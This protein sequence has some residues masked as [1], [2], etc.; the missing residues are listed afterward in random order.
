MPSFIS[1]SDRRF[2]SMLALWVVMLS[3]A[4]NVLAGY[5]LK[6]WS[7]LTRRV[8][9]GKFDVAASF[10]NYFLNY[11]RCPIVILGS[12]V[13]AGLPPE[14]WER[15]DVCTITLVG[16]GSFLGLE[17]LAKF[18]AAP[19]VLF[20]ES[21]FGFRD[22]PADQ[23]ATFTDPLHH[24]LHDWLPL[25]TAQGNW[26]NILWRT[27][28]PV[29]SGLY[30]PTESWEKWRETRMAYAD[31]HVSTYG[32]PV[33]DWSRD[34]MEGIL[35]RTGELVSQLEQRGTN[36]V[37]FDSPLDPRIA[38]LPIIELWGRMMHSAFA[39]HEWVADSPAKYYL[40]DGVHFTGGSGKDFFDLLMSHLTSFSGAGKD[41]P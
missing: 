18:P 17:V 20:V 26:I 29:L 1:S 13:A 38:A 22:A 8:Q 33:S 35:K 24:T 23:V 31:I 12:S 16:Q 19:K 14:G 41:M 36:V 30:R 27:Q 21:T 2:I 10:E 7:A 25:T 37:F 39:D 6:H 34:H 32:N 4:A 28:Y 3:V 40:N 15:S 9:M 5:G 11:P